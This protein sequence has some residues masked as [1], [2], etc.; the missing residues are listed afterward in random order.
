MFG[1]TSLY[2]IR[3]VPQLV[4]IE[5]QMV[6]PTPRKCEL[7]APISVKTFIRKAFCVRR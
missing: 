5:K 7:D 3:L 6:Q 1:A 2:L 4:D